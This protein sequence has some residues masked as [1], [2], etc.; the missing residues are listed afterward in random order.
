MPVIKNILNA[1]VDV[2]TQRPVLRFEVNEIH[3]V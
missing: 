2:R 1:P 3:F